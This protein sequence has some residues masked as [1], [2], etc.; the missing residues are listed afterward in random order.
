LLPR[1]RYQLQVVLRGGI[2]CVRKRFP[3]LPA[4][5]GLGPRHWLWE[6]A[7]LSFHTEAAALARLHGCAQVPQLRGVDAASRSVYMDFVAG[8]TLRHALA[9]RGWVH[10]LDL[11]ADPSLRR[12]TSDESERREAELSSRILGQSYGCRVNELVR[13][14]NLHG[15][16]L[17]DIKPGNVF[18]G[19][20]TG[21]L[22]WHDFEAAVLASQ[23]GWEQALAEQHRRLDFWFG[24]AARNDV[25]AV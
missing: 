12:L 5:S 20:R 4:I 23:P 15:V 25:L 19:A 24:T 1:L 10:D 8:E 6:L 18:V 13:A 17:Q 3:R 14:I 11:A 7:G 21:R 16:A 9:G 22:Y 2:V